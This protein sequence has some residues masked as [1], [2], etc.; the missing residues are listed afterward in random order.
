MAKA[1]IAARGWAKP[2]R[3]FARF[4]N[5]SFRKT[6][7]SVTLLLVMDPTQSVNAAAKS[8]APEPSLAA[9]SGFFWLGVARTKFYAVGVGASR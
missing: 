7:I 2:A 5:N 6:E 1:T 9:F 3:A 4:S 8:R